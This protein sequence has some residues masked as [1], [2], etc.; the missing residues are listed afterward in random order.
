MED[1]RHGQGQP[2]RRVRRVE[3]IGPV[4]GLAEPGSLR[5]PRADCGHPPVHLVEA[6]VADG[7]A[8]L[9]SDG[10]RP[11]CRGAVILDAV[12]DGEAG[13]RDAHPN[14]DGDAIES[15]D[16]AVRPAP[17]LP[18]RLL[19]LAG[20]AVPVAVKPPRVSFGAAPVALEDVDLRQLVLVPRLW[21][22]L[23]ARRNPIRVVPP[24]VAARQHKR[25]DP[26]VGA[27]VAELSV[28]LPL[29][30]HLRQTVAHRKVDAPAA[31]HRLG[32]RQAQV[33]LEHEAVVD[34]RPQR[35][36]GVSPP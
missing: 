1:V 18:V 10:V 32:L 34:G 28:D 23:V 35:V 9:C 6:V 26:V 25:L 7:A 22:R 13:G 21:P 31:V 15:R 20:D 8:R 11:K 33:L 36:V 16:A 24:L 19:A 12:V 14:G 30:V 5:V 2:A 4:V 3:V 27:Q 17:Y 29:P